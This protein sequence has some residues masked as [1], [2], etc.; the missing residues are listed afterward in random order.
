MGHLYH[1]KLLVIT[2]GYPIHL[3]SQCNHKKWL[4]HIETTC[5]LSLYKSHLAPSI[6]GGSSTFIIPFQD[7]RPKDE[8]AQGRTGHVSHLGQRPGK[9][10][11]GTIICVYILYIYTLYIYTLYI[12]NHNIIYIYIYIIYI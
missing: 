4:N 12:Y 2:S 7:G 3:P 6:N 11:L 8:M 10:M 9:T 5:G 1:G